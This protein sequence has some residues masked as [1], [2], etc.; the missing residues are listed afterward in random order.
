MSEANGE[1]MPDDAERS[2]RSGRMQ[3]D[4]LVTRSPALGADLG[5][6]TPGPGDGTG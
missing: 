4:L 1:V 3:P 5:L 2:S 6:V